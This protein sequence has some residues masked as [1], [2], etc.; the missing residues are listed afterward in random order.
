MLCVANTH[1][2]T[3]SQSLVTSANPVRWQRNDFTLVS[4]VMK[5]T[6]GCSHLTQSLLLWSISLILRVLSELDVFPFNISWQL[7]NYFELSCDVVVAMETTLMPKAC[8]PYHRIE[9]YCPLCMLTY[10]CGF[11]KI[12]SILLFSPRHMH[13]MLIIQTSLLKVTHSFET[14]LSNWEPKILGDMQPRK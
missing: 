7:R 6:G 1:H 10:P 3:L 14:R 11:L 12:I 8:K 4:C 13:I 9:C 2:T 5:G